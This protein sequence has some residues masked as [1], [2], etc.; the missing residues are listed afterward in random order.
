MYCLELQF[1]LPKWTKYPES[2]CETMI[3]DDKSG[4]KNHP[5][6]NGLESL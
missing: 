6:K 5:G 2:Y 3:F 4:V 1:N